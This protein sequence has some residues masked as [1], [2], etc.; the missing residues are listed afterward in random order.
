MSHES[1]N[2][3][4]SPDT[5]ESSAPE[6]SRRGIKRYLPAGLF[7]RALL[8]LGLPTILLQAVAIYIFYESHWD[9]IVRN[10]SFSL[11][12]EVAMLVYDTHRADPSERNYRKEL[13]GQMMGMN[14]EF[15]PPEAWVDRPPDP[16]FSVFS[17]HLERRITYPFTITRPRDSRYIL[18][19]I[20]YPDAV[21]HI[22]ASKKRLISSTTV[23]F[24]IWLVG[25]AAILLTVAVLFMRNQVRPITHLA[26][27]AEGFG[28]GVD[29]PAFRP[30]GAREV[31]QAA[32]AFL[33]MRARITRQIESRTAMLAGISHDMRTPLTRMKLQLEMM[34]DN[35]ETQ[36][37]RQDMEEMRHMVEEYLD[38]ARGEEGEEPV[39][40]DLGGLVAETV[41]AHSRTWATI[42]LLPS[43]TVTMKLRP[44]A[45][46]RALD[47]LI[48]NAVQY[49]KACRIALNVSE[50][51]A[52]IRVEDDGPGIDEQEME[53]AFR[54]FRRLDASRDPNTGGAGLGLSIARDIVRTH[55]GDITLKNR[56]DE[57]GKRIGLEARIRL[58]LARER[59]A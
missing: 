6:P 39:L 20:R 33:T 48:L 16:R 28:R 50:H 58:P 13:T 27:A 5:P 19:D 29:D 30:S 14:I 59:T 47:N 35:E 3:M 31:R 57:Q 7:G 41:E 32:R 51:A 45:F 49:G 38:F 37:L 52:I 40:T 2:P 8:I 53:T 42:T 12:G 22:E 36:L 11:A 46:R 55:G 23:V 34:P 56:L 15:R 24:V 17:H 1:P 10:M 9:S 54:P 26:R 43:D 4:N 18:I 21:L 44:R 25:S